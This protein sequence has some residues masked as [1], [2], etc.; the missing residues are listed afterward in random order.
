[1]RL[2]ISHKPPS[3]PALMMIRHRVPI[4]PRSPNARR[5]AWIGRRWRAASRS[6]RRR[7]KW[8]RAEGQVA[9]GAIQLPSERRRIF[10]RFSKIKTC[11]SPPRTTH[12]LPKAPAITAQR[13]KAWSRPASSSASPSPLNP[14]LW[15]YH[16]LMQF[17]TWLRT[18]A[19]PRLRTLHP[20]AFIRLWQMWTFLCSWVVSYF[21]TAFVWKV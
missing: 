1:M 9:S 11:V 3:D 18:R 17:S 6:R 7:G 10:P 20:R 5:R 14:A 16:W 2:S 4:K 12:T 19:R 15:N 8:T 13:S 21:L